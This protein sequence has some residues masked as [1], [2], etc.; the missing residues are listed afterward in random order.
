MGL[1]EHALIVLPWSDTKAIIVVPLACEKKRGGGTLPGERAIN[2]PK[3]TAKAGGKR[4]Q[5]T[6]GVTYVGNV[7]WPSVGRGRS[8]LGSTT[9]EVAIF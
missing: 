6:L 1:G 3:A 4:L 9:E 7:K 2:L 8:R 5:E